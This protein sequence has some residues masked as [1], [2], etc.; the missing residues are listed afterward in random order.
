MI[1]SEYKTVVREKYAAEVHEGAN[2]DQVNDWEKRKTEGKIDRI[3]DNLGR[4]PA[5][6][7]L[8]AVYF[9]AGWSAA[10][11]KAATREDDFKLSAAQTVRVPMMRQDTLL[12]LA[13]GPG[14]RAVR[15][16]YSQRALGMIIVLPEEIEGLDA[17]TR[18][19]DPA[20][21]A[22]LHAWLSGGL[23]RPVSLALPRFKAAFEADLIEPVRKAGMALAFADN[24]DFSGMSGKR[25]SEGGVKIGQIRH[26]AIIEVTEGG[27]EAA[28]ATAVVMVRKSLPPKRPAP[29]PFHRRP[30]VPVLCRR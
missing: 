3:L 20:E 13:E 10:F 18:Q 1:S 27:T 30:P 24:A 21:L 7:P 15:L 6:V 5:A 2:L 14:Y 16:N 23:E 11:A 26:R 9:K 25:T 29:V 4:D 22:K 28:A 19:L 17:V 12:R 8:N